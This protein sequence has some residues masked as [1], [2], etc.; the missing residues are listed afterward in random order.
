VRRVYG[1]YRAQANDLRRQYQRVPA[2]ADSD[3][4]RHL[5]QWGSCSAVV[6]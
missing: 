1:Q 6:G 4:G 2:L 5:L 3:A